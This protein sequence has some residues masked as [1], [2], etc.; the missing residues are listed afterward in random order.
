MEEMTPG[1]ELANNQ[2]PKPYAKAYHTSKSV[3][4]PCNY[5]AEKAKPEKIMGQVMAAK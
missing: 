3:P 4:H 1:L 5:E 2:N